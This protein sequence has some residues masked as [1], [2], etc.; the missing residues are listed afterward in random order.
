MR[1]AEASL[2]LAE[3]AAK[4]ADAQVDAGKV[5]PVEATRADMQLATVQ[6]DLRRARK[7]GTTLDRC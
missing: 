6:L 4:V 7:N 1:L 2:S 3:R 5:S